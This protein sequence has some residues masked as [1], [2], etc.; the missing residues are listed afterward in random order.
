MLKRWIQDAYR[1][2]L[3]QL[4]KQ[5]SGGRFVP[6][7]K[8]SSRML[9]QRPVNKML[10]FPFQH[11]VGSSELLRPPAHNAQLIARGPSTQIE[12]IYPEA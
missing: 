8:H 10:V 4:L 2:M 6:H 11:R 12:G 3:Q 7:E 9:E 1:G 5:L